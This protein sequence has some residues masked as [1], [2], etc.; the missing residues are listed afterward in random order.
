M[1]MI[2][3]QMVCIK[4]GSVFEGL[5]SPLPVCPECEKGE[6]DPFRIALEHRRILRRFLYKKAT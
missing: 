1:F 5:W 2:L 6:K 4:C 3:T